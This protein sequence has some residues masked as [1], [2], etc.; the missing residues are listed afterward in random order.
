MIY[1]D[2]SHRVS[3]LFIQFWN[4]C[5]ERALFLLM[6]ENVSENNR[7]MIACKICDTNRATTC[8]TFAVSDIFVFYRTVFDKF[9][10]SAIR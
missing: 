7:N 10:F 9:M 6:F 8:R 2:C 1:S 5:V 4:A 3:I